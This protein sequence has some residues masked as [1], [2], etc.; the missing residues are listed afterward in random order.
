[1]GFPVSG[2]SSEALSLVNANW[3]GELKKVFRAGESLRYDCHTPGTYNT[4]ERIVHCL[5]NRIWSSNNP[6]CECMRM[7]FLIRYN[8]IFLIITMSCQRPPSDIWQE[9]I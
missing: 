8:L 2:C 5:G 1:M 6:G 3:S 4:T 9:L 7:N